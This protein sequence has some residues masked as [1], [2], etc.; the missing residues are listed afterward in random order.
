VLNF[1]VWRP[2]IP[3]PGPRLRIPSA[4]RQV[5]GYNCQPHLSTPPLQRT[6][7]TMGSFIKENWI[8]IAGPVVFIL[9]GVGFLIYLSSMDSGAGGSDF[10]YDL[11]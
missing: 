10:Q 11:F 8:W 6:R 2:T 7:D 4:Q 1:R 5:P 3:R 9:A